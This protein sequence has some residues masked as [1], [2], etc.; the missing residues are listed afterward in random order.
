M[1]MQRRRIHITGLG[2]S[3]A[4]DVDRLSSDG[5]DG[6][7]A[8]AREGVGGRYEVTSSRR[9]ICA[10][11]AEATGGRDDDELRARELTSTLADDRVAALVTIRGGAWFTRILNRV[12]FDVLRK[13]R[14]RIYLFGFSE[15]TTLINIAAQH[16]RAVALYDLGPTF[17][18]ASGQR[19]ALRHFDAL[20]RHVNI[21]E[22]KRKAFATGWALARFP[23]AF[24]DFFRDV[25]DIIDGKGS[26]RISTGRLLQGRLTARSRITIVG[27]TL[28]V[29]LPL[30]ASKYAPAVDTR[31]KWLALEDVNEDVDP[32]DRM[33]AALQLAGLFE[34]AAGVILGNFHKSDQELSERAFHIL[35]HHLPPRRSVPV[36]TLDT[37]GHVDGIAPLPINRPVTLRRLPGRTSS[38]GVVLDVPWPDWAKD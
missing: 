38:G 11:H 12:N 13:R 25:A 31:G 17:L 36:I 19:H 3:A 15:M 6:M 27:G 1:A 8:L 29:V 2:S 4:R 26:S 21:S 37:F 14:T 10:K 18:F 35:R 32:I 9:L 22:K 7:L 34:R 33:M 30:L 23:I 5:F 16:E 20:A 24:A 28:S